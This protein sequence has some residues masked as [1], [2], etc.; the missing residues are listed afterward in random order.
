MIK[1]QYLSASPQEKQAQRI[2]ALEARRALLPDERKSSEQLVCSALVSMPEVNQAKVIFS[3]MAMREE[4]PLHCFHEWAHKEGK[5]LA[6]PV[7]YPGGK[8]DAFIPSG[9]T[10]FQ[11]GL[12]GITEPNPDM[13]VPVQPEDIDL[14]LVPCVAFDNDGQRLGYGG[15]YYDR[16]LPKCSKAIKILTAYAAQ[17]L[18]YVA[19]DSLDV[20]MDVLVTERG[21][22]RLY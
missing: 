19:T 8:M 2:A 7:S 10:A 1:K 6:Y 13:S 9:P 4:L 16:Y 12:H 14:I 22:C 15:G 3:Y 21:I 17:Q 11:E 18:P 20:P 5:V